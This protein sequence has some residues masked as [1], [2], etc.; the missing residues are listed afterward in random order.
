MR[1]LARTGLF[2]GVLA[3]LFSA[4]L[5]APPYSPREQSWRTGDIVFMNG[6]SW[7]SVFVRLAQGYSRDYSHVGLVSVRDGVAY[8]IH[9]SPTAGKE[10]AGAIVEERWDVALGAD[11]VTG[12]AVYR[13]RRSARLRGDEVRLQ[14]ER[15]LAARLPFDDA[16]DLSTADR[17]YCTELIWRA[18]RSIGVDL[19]PARTGKYL[20]PGDLLGSDSLREVAVF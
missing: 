18:Y 1:F 9:A 14:A 16:F 5:G 12:G 2:T 10:A 15:F 6:R 20:F 17:L 8:I 19:R 4:A 11:R 13:L 3:V 7:R